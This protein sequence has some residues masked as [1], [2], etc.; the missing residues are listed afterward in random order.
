MELEEFIAISYNNVSNKTFFSLIRDLLTS[1]HYQTKNTEITN[2]NDTLYDILKK[3]GIDDNVIKFRC[4]IRIPKKES[5][6]QI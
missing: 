3:I 6:Q 4:L 5:K 1:D 2:L